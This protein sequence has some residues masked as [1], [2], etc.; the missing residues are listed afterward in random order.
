MLM[1]NI[2]NQVMKTMLLSFLLVAVM[3]VMAQQDSTYAGL[4]DEVQT[5]NS[6]LTRSHQ[7]KVAAFLFLGSG[8][9]LLNLGI[10]NFTMNDAGSSGFAMIF[11]T[12]AIA[13]S[14]PLFVQGFRNKRRA[15]LLMGNKPIPL[16]HKYSYSLPSLG[17]RIGLCK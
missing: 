9:V 17:V 10:N 11:G 2:K 8:L 7:Q 16:T 5:S 13:G 1:T 15:K 6:Y 12:A 14:I 3:E 4:I